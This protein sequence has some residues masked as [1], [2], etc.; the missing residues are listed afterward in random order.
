[1]LMLSF[2]SN[3]AVSS[4]KVNFAC[5]ANL[6]L[7]FSKYDF[8]CI[9]S[10]KKKITILIYLLRWVCNN[11][12]QIIIIVACFNSLRLKLH[13]LE[14]NRCYPLIHPCVNGYMWVCACGCRHARIGG[15]HTHSNVICSCKAVRHCLVPIWHFCGFLLEIIT[16]TWSTLLNF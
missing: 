13:E 7:L 8:R 16:L 14:R 4:L 1:M 10:G 12:I 6:I 2:S 3:W 15:V 5:V 9:V 11:S